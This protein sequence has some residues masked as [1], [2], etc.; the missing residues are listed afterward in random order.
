MLAVVVCGTFDARVKRTKAKTKTSAATT[1]MTN[2]T[3][4]FAS[5][6]DT[7]MVKELLTSFVDLKTADRDASR[8]LERIK[9]VYDKQTSTAAKREFRDV[10]Y[11]ALINYQKINKNLESLATIDAYQAIAKSNDTH[12]PAMCF[13]KGDISAHVL[14]DT[15][16]LKDCI[17]EL[18]VCDKTVRTT[19][20]ITK[21]RTYLQE[22]RDYI[23][24]C[25]RLGTGLWISVNRFTDEGLPYYTVL[26]DYSNPKSNA[27]LIWGDVDSFG[28]AQN[29]TELMNDCAYFAWSNEKLDIPSNLSVS[30][31]NNLAAGLGNLTSSAL[32]DALGSS[33]LGSLGGDLIGSIVGSL[34]KQDPK[35]VINIAE[36]TIHMVNDFEM[37][38][39][40]KGQTITVTQDDQKKKEYNDENVLF[41]KI[42]P[43][44]MSKLI[45]KGSVLGKDLSKVIEELSIDGNKEQ[46][47][48]WKKR[49]SS[50]RAIFQWN[51]YQLA[52]LYD[53]YEQIM[54]SE[55][56]TCSSLYHNN[57]DANCL[58]LLCQEI[59]D[60]PKVH[61]KYPNIKGIF[62]NDYYSWG[63]AAIYGI[64]KGDIITHIDGFECGSV[65]E[66]KGYIQSLERFSPVKVKLLR[67]KK[68]VEI[69]VEHIG[70]YYA[71]KEEL[72]SKFF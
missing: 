4:S 32:S 43:G 50:M 6:I 58:G 44:I 9:S 25:D 45:G 35:K 12:L 47:K 16:I 3:Q 65:R 15:L 57:Q 5:S 21:L 26:A 46:I 18:S 7:T 64:K 61:K 68:E 66:A 70:L 27:I 48:I 52:Q 39:K 56:I 54:R 34:F 71:A 42:T 67:D 69:E 19:E 60:N 40:L 29:I 51:L 63:T 59:V 31:R 24:V 37:V 22:I 36:A 1:V 10:I 33:F 17:A 20:Y 13:V 72:D 28:V 11:Q 62:V 14:N 38:A 8:A 53:Y 2:N 49:L 30:L 23:P 55:K 41:M